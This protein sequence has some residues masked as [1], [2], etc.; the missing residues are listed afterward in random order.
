MATS[1]VYTVFREPLAQLVERRIVVAGCGFDPHAVPSI[2]RPGRSYGRADTVHMFDIPSR[3]SP[4][5]R[6]LV[7]SCLTC[8][9][10]GN[11]AFTDN[12]ALFAGLA[13]I[14]QEHRKLASD[15]P[16]TRFV[17]IEGRN[18]T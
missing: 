6:I 11:L 10:G 3:G 17:F 5:P 15:C 8:L 7:W 9:N 13:R 14:L 1:R 2:H 18:G 4:P 16:R 12:D